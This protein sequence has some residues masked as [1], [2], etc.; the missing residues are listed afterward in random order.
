M[1]VYNNTNTASPLTSVEFAPVSDGN[2][3]FFTLNKPESTDAIRQWLTSPDVGQEIV[4]ETSVNGKPILV[5]HGDKTKD[6]MMKA[7]E[8]HGEK[9]QLHIHKKPFNF[10]ALR[11]SM[12][13]IA[14]TLTIIASFI[15]VK[16][17]SAGHY[18]KRDVHV[19]TLAFSILNQ[20]ANVTNIVYG[21]QQ[22]DD[23]NRLNVLKDQLNDELGPH[24]RKGENVFDVDDR[25]SD[26]RKGPQA[27]LSPLEQANQMMKENS[28]RIGEI[29]LRYLGSMFLAFPVN[30]IK[31]GLAKLRTGNLVAAYKAF[32]NPDHII[33]W[34]GMGYLTGKTLALFAKV[35]DPY[36]DK[37][38]TALD[39]FREKYLFK[40]AGLIEAA[41][42]YTTMGRRWNG[43]IGIKNKTGSYSVMPDWPQRIGGFLFGSGYVVRYFAKFGQ[44]NLDMEE[45]YAHAEDTMAK[46]PPEKLPQLLANTAAT[47]AAD[48][49]LNPAGTQNASF[50]EIFTKMMSDL[51]RYHH[52][53]LDNLGTEPEER[54]AKIT[55]TGPEQAT[56]TKYASVRGARNPMDRVAKPAASRADSVSKTDE[57]HL[58]LGV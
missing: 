2:F 17:N 4:A 49:K 3:T 55:E 1:A 23:T 39:T 21:G 7:L 6:E 18:V 45:V 27:P 40:Y 9:L 12:S 50:G 51:Y 57:K 14:H 5:T 13:V 32:R 24:L 54:M 22:T 15:Q 43:T 52:I 28:V 34:A 47:I 56:P 36:S 11:G 26:L 16:K 10:W 33:R 29:A 58:S 44:R 25:R 35:P 48:T 30:H 53:A 46:T 19:D 41:S 38:H 42:G 20:L 8:A 31:P 37:P